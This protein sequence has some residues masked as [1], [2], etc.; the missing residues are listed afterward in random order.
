MTP[1]SLSS[2]LAPER[3]RVGLAVAS[4]DALLDALVDLLD[5]A[6]AVDDLDALREAVWTREQQMSTGVGLGLALPHARTDAASST[7]AAF[8][9]LAEPVPYGALDGQPVTMALLLAGPETDRRRHLRLLSH[10]SLVMSDQGVRSQLAAA[11]GAAEVQR[12]IEAAE[13]ESSAPAVP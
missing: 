10:V 1:I 13:R 4:K 7:L 2:L 6:P 12:V 8:A 5:G 11:G 9:T 3:I